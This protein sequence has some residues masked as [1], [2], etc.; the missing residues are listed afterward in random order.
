[1]AS[2][3]PTRTRFNCRRPYATSLNPFGTPPPSL[4]N[5]LPPLCWAGKESG[6]RERKTRFNRQTRPPL[7]VFRS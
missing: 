5:P 2:I 4:P 6:D 3:S 7:P 1:M